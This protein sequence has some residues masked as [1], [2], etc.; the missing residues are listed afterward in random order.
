[1]LVGITLPAYSVHNSNTNLWALD[2]VA[3]VL[4]VVGLSTAYCAD[5]Q[6]YAYMRANEELVAAGK[7]TRLVLDTGLWRYSRHPNYLGETIWWFGFGLFAVSVGQW[8]MLGGWLLNTAVLIQVTFMT[9]ERMKTNRT[10][11]RL[12]A[13][14]AY[15]KT[16][17]C[18]IL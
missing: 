10:G 4:C 14:L 2:G 12:R 8:Y 11:E 6:L 5:T 1:M 15:Q 16:T 13:F 7:P 18:W 3:M 17:S 9:E